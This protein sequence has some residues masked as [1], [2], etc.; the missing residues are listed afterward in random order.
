[1]KKKFGFIY[2]S[3]FILIIFSNI[4]AQERKI[5]EQE[6][7]AVGKNWTFKGKAYRV[8]KSSKF[9]DKANGKTINIFNEISEY[10]ASGDS[11]TVIE[12]GSSFD[13]MKRVENFIIGK[14]IYNLHP[15]GKWKVS[16]LKFESE[17]QKARRTTQYP[18]I[19]RISEHFYKGKTLLNNQEVELYESKYIEKS[20]RNSREFVTVTISKK[21]YNKEGMPLKIETTGDNESGN[22]YSV[23]E[24]ELDPDIKIEA[25]VK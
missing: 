1:M 4:T 23:F 24:F 10:T 2:C 20:K 15:R 18:E 13:N 7:N 21:W 11:H 25:P 6:M 9:F 22:S 17:E 12:S 8:K 16:E 14:T 3:L 19:E 5:T